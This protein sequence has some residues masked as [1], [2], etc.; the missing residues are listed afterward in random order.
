[1]TARTTE[2]EDDVQAWAPAP[3]SRGLAQIVWQRKALVILGAVVGLAVGSLVYA[4]RPPVYQSTAQVFVVKKRSSSLPIGPAVDTR[5]AYMEDYVASH[6]ILFKSPLIIEKAVQKRALGSLKSLEGAADPAGIIHASIV[7]GRDTTSGTNAPSNVVNLSYRGPV[8]EDCGK[9]L[10][11]VIESY[12]DFLD[13]SYHSVGEETLDQIT[14]ARNTL[15]NDVEKAHKAYRKFLETSQVVWKGKDG[16]N[17][18]EGQM[19][20]L[21]AKRFALRL[22]QTELKERIEALQK[23]IRESRGREMV[24]LLPPSRESKMTAADRAVEQQLLPLLLEEQKLLQDYGKHHP[25]VLQIRKSIAMTRDFIKRM[26]GGADAAEEPDQVKSDPAQR[27]LT[28]LELEQREGELGLQALD[29]MVKELKDEAKALGFYDLEERELRNNITQLEQL[30]AVTIK[31]LTELTLIR[32][33]GGF[34]ARTIARPGP[35]AKVAPIL[36]QWLL[37]GLMLGMLAGVG[38]AYLADISDKSFRT[39]DEVR[40]QLGLPLV[41]HIPFLKPDP[42]TVR[43]LGAGEPLPDPL[44]CTYYRPKSVEAEAYRAVRTALYFSTQGEG[45]KV[46][47]VTSPNKGDG[48]SLLIANLAISIAQSGKRVL[49]VDADC[50]RPRQHKVFNLPTL[51][52][53]ASVIS[54]ADGLCDAVQETAV[55]GLWLLPCGPIPPNPAELLTAPRFKDLLDELRGQYDFVLVDT[56]PLLAVTDPCVVAPR[57]D[58]LF[59]ALRLSR[60]GRPNALRA[61]EI[62]APLGV[63]ILGVVINGVARQGGAGLYA[64]DSYE[65]SENYD[66]DTEEGS[67]YTDDEYQEPPAAPPAAEPPGLRDPGAAQGVMP[68]EDPPHRRPG[69]RGGLLSWLLGGWI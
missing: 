57:V 55:P 30:H 34:N 21:D 23:A 22:R 59:L 46:I 10:A 51:K 28:M 48:K 69:R 38:L 44:L 27:L 12:Q 29:K 8:S 67:Y 54:G 9:I 50:R 31:R 17:P 53:L 42:E 14:K 62:L 60:Q 3:A 41:G 36:T 26:L 15:K 58:G 64:A 7:A 16:A 13:I 43:R 24:A 65:Y 20:N 45:H 11:A 37:I 1:M 40:R 4:Q 5:A 33:A 32:E 66:E 52:G 18:Q 35:G 56:P 49:L 2:P 63:N 61:K 39:P 47:Q 6:L 68:A 25:K 19:T